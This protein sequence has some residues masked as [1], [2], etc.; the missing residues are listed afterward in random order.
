M[1]GM[2]TRQ[3][4]LTGCVL[5]TG[6]VAAVAAL[7]DQPRIALAGLAVLAALAV[8]LLLDLRARVARLNRRLRARRRAEHEAVALHAKVAELDESLLAAQEQA[9]TAEH[10]LARLDDLEQASFRASLR[11][12]VRVFRTEDRLKRATRS[13]A[14]QLPYKL[15]NLEFA[16][17]HGIGVPTVYQVWPDVASIDLSALPDTFVLKADGGAGSVAV[18]P[19]RRVGPDRYE[20]V[21]ATGQVAQAEILD[22]LRSLGRAARPPFFA[23]E[24]LTAVGGG[25]IPND[26][27]LYMFHGEVGHVLTRYVGV[28]GRAG[29]IRLRFIDEQ[30]A[31]FGP[32]AIGRKHDPAIEV[33]PSLAQMVE[34]ARHLSRAVG[35]PF[36]RVDLYDT[37]RGIVLG[38]V[39]RAPNG[40]NDRYTEEHDQL[41]GRRWLDGAARLSADLSAGRPSG[42]LFGTVADLRLYPP[43][44]SPRA[45]ANFERTIVD[46]SQWC[47]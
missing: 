5:L 6:A 16:A 1:P 38:E 34:A 40:G 36:C 35:L 44:D 39:T 7:L 12:H 42:T 46:C 30:G 10:E 33:P 3:R 24:L 32:V 25:P 2:T 11:Q 26:V 22:L 29:T 17:S 8:V 18:F 27:K 14:L 45:A 41:L 13:A 28:H 47:G 37:S 21:G 31:D 4:A 9:R 20:R 19:L 23:E 43:H 15:R